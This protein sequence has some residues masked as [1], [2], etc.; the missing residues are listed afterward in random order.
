MYAAQ[1]RWAFG[2]SDMKMLQSCEVGILVR[3][4]SNRG[5]A[6]SHFL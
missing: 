4:D 5:V 6:V 3:T 1:F 2:G